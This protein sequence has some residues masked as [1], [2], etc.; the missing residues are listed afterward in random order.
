MQGRSLLDL[1]ESPEDFA[2]R[3]I[4][5]QLGRRVAVRVGSRKW[6]ASG[7][8]ELRGYDLAR[9][10]AEQRPK[11]GDDRGRALVARYAARADALRARLDHPEADAIETDPAT[12]AELRALGYIE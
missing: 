10:P 4:F 8:G 6:I 3:P 11:E 7:S 2:D 12:E 1:V 9:D 5:A